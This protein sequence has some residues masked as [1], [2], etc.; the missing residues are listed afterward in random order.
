MSSWTNVAHKVTGECILIFT[1][2][3]LLQEP[4]CEPQQHTTSDSVAS[5]FTLL[6]FWATALPPLDSPPQISTVWSPPE[7]SPQHQAC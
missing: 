3:A 4:V 2:F 1:K 6:P 5:P 7:N